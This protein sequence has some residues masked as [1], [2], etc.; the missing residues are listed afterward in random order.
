MK[1]T[2]VGG[3][4]AG[5]VALSV[6]VAGPAHADSTNAQFF[7]DMRAAGLYADNG[8]GTLLSLGHSFCARM[9]AGA[10]SASLVSELYH[11]SDPPLDGAQRFV[12]ITITDLCPWNH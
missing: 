5:A 9:D 12:T 6:A 1:K 8:E 7:R 2:I 10:S 3:L 4:A 11:S